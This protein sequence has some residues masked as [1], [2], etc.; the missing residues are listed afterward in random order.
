VFVLLYVAALLLLAIGTFGWFGAERD[1]LAAVYLVPL[2]LPWTL[3][4]GNAPE[5]LVPWLA[6]ASPGLNLVLIVAMCRLLM[7]LKS[8][9]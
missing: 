4:V 1:P 2:G 7:N 5:P 3:L 9:G 6:I 8:G